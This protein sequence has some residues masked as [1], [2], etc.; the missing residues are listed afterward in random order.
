MNDEEIDPV[1]PGDGRSEAALDAAF[2]GAKAGLVAAI[3]EGLDLDAGL[4]QIVGTPPQ[5][6]M[7]ATQLP[8]EGGVKC[9]HSVANG[10]WLRFPVAAETPA[11]DVSTQIARLR[12]RILE[13]VQQIQERNSVVV[14][15]TAAASNL[16]DLHRGLEARE[17][18]RQAAAELLDETDLALDTASDLASETR[19]EASG[20][21]DYWVDVEPD[22]P[23]ALSRSSFWSARSM[24]F[25]GVLS[26]ILAALV[27]TGLAMINM[28]WLH[29]ALAALNLKRHGVM[30]ATAAAEAL[31]L[32]LVLFRVPRRLLQLFRERSERMMAVTEAIELRTA[33][34]RQTAD[35]GKAM[36]ML[37]KSLQSE[38]H[39]QSVQMTTKIRLAT[40][41]S[42]LQS[43][44]RRSISPANDLTSRIRILREELGSVRPNVMRLFDE[45]DDCSPCGSR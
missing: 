2:L 25:W 29:T 20:E 34:R 14:L 10:M 22:S 11:V 30:E 16:R 27:G 40:Y 36:A 39:E 43:A 33:L 3:R 9:H 26:G 5:L 21:D 4:A 38:D 32:S 8:T 7:Y 6:E 28:S 15:L 23:P 12:F 35:V 44:A 41:T 1:A 18:S 45:A 37:K 31:M 42:I 24:L 13:L 17:L 19:A